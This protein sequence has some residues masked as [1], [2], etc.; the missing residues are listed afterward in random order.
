MGQ[1]INLQD[2]VDITS[3]YRSNKETILGNAYKNQGILPVCE[4]FNRDVISDLLAQTNCSGIRIYFSMASDYKVKVTIVGYDSNAE[5]ILPR[6]AELIVEE[7]QR[8][9]P[10]CPP[11]SPLNS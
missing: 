7:G 11:S 4:S 10:D 1:F 8:C 6:D 9:P 3:R 5:D 2:A